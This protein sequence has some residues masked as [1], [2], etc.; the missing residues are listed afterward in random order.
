ME[1]NAR[2]TGLQLNTALL[3]GTDTFGWPKARCTFPAFVTRSSWRDLAGSR[4]Y[5]ANDMGD[6]IVI[7]VTSS[8]TVTHQA[9]PQRWPRQRQSQQ[10]QQQ[11]PA[12]QWQPATLILCHSIL[13][14]NASSDFFV[15]EAFVLDGWSVLD[16]RQSSCVLLFFSDFL[17][18]VLGFVFAL[19]FSLVVVF[20]HAD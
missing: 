4:V 14:A 19:G 5:R 20:I 3:S 12:G 16:D 13:E 6:S 7:T 10:Q 1:Y 15:A 17:P 9:Q 11:Q 18:I 8:S 2:L